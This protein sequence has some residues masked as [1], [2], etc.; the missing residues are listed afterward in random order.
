MPVSGGNYTTKT[1]SRITGSFV[2]FSVRSDEKSLKLQQSSCGK[3]AM[4]IVSTILPIPFFV[5][6]GFAGYLH[7]K[8]VSNWDYI[9]PKQVFEFGKKLTTALPNVFSLVVSRALLAA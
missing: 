5:Y 8:D 1:R 9:S 3:L 7:G 2:Q 4:A 6:G